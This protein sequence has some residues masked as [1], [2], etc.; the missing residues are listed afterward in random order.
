M[1]DRCHGQSK[2]NRTKAAVELTSDS[3]GA[4]LQHEFSKT[5]TFDPQIELTITN[6]SHNHKR[7]SQ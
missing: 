1:N 4:V 6:D 5:L 2:K 7:H 3:T